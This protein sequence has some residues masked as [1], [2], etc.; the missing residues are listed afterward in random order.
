MEINQKLP[1]IYLDLLKKSLTRYVFDDG[2]LSLYFRNHGRFKHLLYRTIGKVLDPF[3]LELVKHN[4]FNPKVRELGKDWPATADT[5]IGLVGLNNIQECVVNILK[6]DIPG[7]LIETGVWR[8]GA[9]IFMRGILKTYNIRDRKVWVADSFA[10]LP[11]PSNDRF[12]EDMIDHLDTYP[13]LRVSLKEVKINFSKYGLL[14]NQVKFLVGW[15]KDTLPKAQIKHLSLLRLDGD[16]YESTMVAL[17]ALYPKLS[18][19]GYVII[20]DYCL[21]QCK[22]ATN[23]YRRLMKIKDPVHAIGN[24]GIFWRRTR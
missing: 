14:D 13:Q 11:K 17:K 20:D 2:Y 22:T 16:M 4:Q 1:Q 9:T 5:M 21:P 24:T 18:I 8:G 15:F 23:D 12:K 19:G 10:G 6:K 7:D 3:S